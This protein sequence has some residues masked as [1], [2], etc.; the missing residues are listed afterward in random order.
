MASIRHRYQITGRQLRVQ[1]I[2]ATADAMLRAQQE[3][4]AAIEDAFGS[5]T[6]QAV[7]QLLATEAAERRGNG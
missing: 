3:L 4:L 6:L 5:D 7:A 1:E 2:R